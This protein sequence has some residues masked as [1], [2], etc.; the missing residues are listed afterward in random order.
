M[1]FEPAERGDLSSF[2][3]YLRSLGGP[4]DS[5]LEKAIVASEF[6][7]II[8]DGDEV[9]AIGLRDGSL[10]THFHLVGPHRRYTRS[11]WRSMMDAFTVAEAYVPTCDEQFLSQALDDYR[12][13]GKQAC[14]FEEGGEVDAASSGVGF[15]LATGSDA[16][17]IHALSGD[18][19]DPLAARL[20]H[21][22]IH[23]GMLADE[24][25]TVGIAEP[26]LFFADQASIGMFTHEAHR[27]RGIGTA[28]IRYL[29]GVC[30]SGGITPIA[31]C[32]YYNDASRQTLQAAGMVTKTRLLKFT[33]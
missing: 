10:L 6:H 28:M 19:L 4:L 20:E 7:R 25:V 27:K 9:G 29:R 21:G 32:W 22:E 13:I 15:R 16:D 18:F 30:H 12:A 2:P 17:E 3:D 5:F 24:L 31:G 8:V 33:F 14:I 23:L 11:A 26:S 1:R